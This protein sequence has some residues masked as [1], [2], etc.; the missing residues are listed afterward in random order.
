MCIRDRC[1]LNGRKP[2]LLIDPKVDLTAD[3]PSDWIVP[4]EAP[5]GGNFYEPLDRWERVVMSDPI[6]AEIA[7]EQKY[8]SKTN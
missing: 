2:Q 6:L 8:L 1:S 3:L 7:A 4:L 5:V